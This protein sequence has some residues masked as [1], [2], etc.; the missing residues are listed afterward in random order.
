M[1]LERSLPAIVSS[2]IIF[3]PKR[4]TAT[5]WEATRM[6]LL[7]LLMKVMTKHSIANQS[8]LKNTI[9]SHPGKFKERL[10]VV[11]QSHSGTRQKVGQPPGNRYHDTCPV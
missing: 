1:C 4:Y 11:A 8:E 9:R 6:P 7:S 2:K 10:I 5:I 3:S